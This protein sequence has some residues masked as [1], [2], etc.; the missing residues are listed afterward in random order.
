MK[1]NKQHA[2]S[3]IRTYDKDGFRR[4]A[5]CV[6]VKDDSESEVSLELNL[7]FFWNML[8]L[9]KIIHLPS[10]IDITFRLEKTGLTHKPVNT[11]ENLF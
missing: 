9:V 8:T 2:P 1:K 10:G 11:L 7:Y 6:C 5:A 4:R 3:S